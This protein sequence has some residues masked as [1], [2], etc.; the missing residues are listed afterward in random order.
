[1]LEDTPLA[2]TAI[3]V[4]ALRDHDIT[5]LN[6]IKNLVPNL[7][8][9]QTP[10][11]LNQSAQFRIRGIG[12]TRIAAAF[13]PGVGV[14]VDG[15]YFSR[16]VRAVTSVIDIQ[17][18]EVL[19]GLQGTLFGKNSIGGAISLTT[20][21]PHEELES[22]AQVRPGNLGSVDTRAMVNLPILDKLLTRFSISTNNFDG[23]TFNTTTDE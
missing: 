1:M 7:N 19:R 9:Q 16:S 6:E 2:V 4:E 17:R 21:K 13:D 18:I 12:T 14:Y 3:G 11:G 20:V 23:F 5:R 15:V 10:V 22:L 8:W